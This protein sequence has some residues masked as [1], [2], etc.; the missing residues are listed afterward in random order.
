MPTDVMVA[1]IILGLLIILIIYSN[2]SGSIF[3]K[4]I[5]TIKW[6]VILTVVLFGIPVSLMFFFGESIMLGFFVVLFLFFMIGFFWVTIYS[7][8]KKYK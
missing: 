2:S 7:H 6:I 5:N 8:K 4:L 3:N 1:L